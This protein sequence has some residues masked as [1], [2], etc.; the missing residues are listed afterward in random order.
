MTDV[1]N[2]QFDLFIAGGG[3]YGAAIA[4]WAAKSGLKV[5]LLEKNDFS[6]GA[7]SNSLKIV[8]GGIRYLQ[9]LNLK[10]TLKSIAERNRMVR[11]FGHAMTPLQCVMPLKIL[12]MKNPLTA[13]AGFK[14][15]SVLSQ[16]KG[17]TVSPYSQTTMFR[18][19]NSPVVDYSGFKAFAQ[20]TDPQARYPE[21]IPV[22]LLCSAE[23]MGAYIRNYE[24]VK[25]VFQKEDGSI[26]VESMR[27][28]GSSHQY[29]TKVFVDCTGGWN[30]YGKSGDMSTQYVKAVNV[31]L[32][33]KITDK[34]LTLPVDSAN[35]RLLFMCP[36][37]DKTILGTWYFGLDD[38]DY[39]S[40]VDDV[41]LRAMLGDVN[42]YMKTPFSTE[43][44]LDLHVGL[45]PLSARAPDDHDFGAALADETRVIAVGKDKKIFRV[46]GIKFTTSIGDARMA[47]VSILKDASVFETDF[48]DSIDKLPCSISHIEDFR[49][50]VERQYSWCSAAVLDRL[51]GL[52]GARCVEVLDM[53]ESNDLLRVE[54]DDLPDSLLAE[55]DYACLHEKAVHLSDVVYRRIG[56]GGCGLLSVR[57]I[58]CVAARMTRVLDKSTDWKNQEIEG[59]AGRHYVSVKSA[60]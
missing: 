16:S 1:D 22:E 8:H 46:E 3:F 24:A 40:S 59:L 26:A 31:V 32:N 38:E 5:A 55:I 17:H 37:A 33:K 27:E 11:L 39:G 35:A 36:W 15:F 53:A 57:L 2:S 54:I 52:Y 7:S 60:V 43:D 12:S 48:C 29:V 10:R 4:C 30:F 41:T 19:F 14:F 49:R 21:R 23:E 51:I 56:L 28:D 13:Y 18:R 58:A 25:E 44:V 47:L 20:W 50:Q 9:T 42:V 45:L 34:A 6:S